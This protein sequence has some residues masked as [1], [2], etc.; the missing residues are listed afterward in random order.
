MNPDDRS[1]LEA[2]FAAAR[3]MPTDQRFEW[4]EK[5]C[6]DA[7]IRSEVADLLNHDLP[8]GFLGL[9]L[10]PH[11]MP[12]PIHDLALSTHDE[13]LRPERNA[14]LIS[15]S[16]PAGIDGRYQLLQRIGEGG[17]GIVY[18]AEELAPV[19][20]RVAIKLLKPGMDSKSVLARFD[21]ERQ[22][23]AMMDHPGIAKVLDGG[24]VSDGR[25]YFVMELVS[26][27]PIT[28]FCQTQACDHRTK[29]HLLLEV[30]QAVHHAHQKGI[31]HRDLKPSN[32]LVSMQDGKPSIKI[33]DFGIAKALHQPLTDRTLF[34]G[35]QQ[36]IGTPE[37]MSP[38][39]AETSVLGCDTRSDVYSLGVLAYELLTGTTPFDGNAIRK[40]GFSELQRTIREVDPPR[41]S[42]RMCSLGVSNTH[43]K[44]WHPIAGLKSDLDWLVMKALEKDRNRRYDSAQA[45][46]DDL[47]RWL[48]NEPIQARPPNWGYTLRKYLTKHRIATF[49][50]FALVTGLLLAAVGIGY[51]ISESRASKE[52]LRLSTQRSIELQRTADADRNRADSLTYG[53][54]MLGAFESF[55]SGRSKTT[56]ELLLAS[57]AS[58]RGLEWSW[59]SYLA[60]DRGIALLDPSTE[61]STVCHALSYFD[62]G[63]RLIAASRDGHLRIWDTRTARIVRSWYAHPSEIL[64][65]AV[66]P[67]GTRFVSG[68]AMG[69]VHVWD[70]NGNPLGTVHVDQPVTALAI[71]PRTHQVAI[72]GKQGSLQWLSW[73]FQG[74][75]KRVSSDARKHTGDIL[76]LAFDEQSPRLLSAGKGGVYVWDTET[77]SCVGGSGDFWQTYRFTLAPDF[78]SI[79][80]YGPPIEVWNVAQQP[81]IATGRWN[82]TATGISH[83]AFDAR[84]NSLLL[85]TADNC[86]QSVDLKTGEHD[87]VAYTKLSEIV[88]FA[89]ADD[90]SS[91]VVA[92][93]D[94]SLR[95]WPRDAW[96]SKTRLDGLR[97]PIAQ[98]AV[99]RIDQVVAIDESGRIQ[100]WNGRTGQSL[101]ELPSHSQQGFSIDV[102]PDGR[103]VVSYGLDQNLHVWSV[104]E[105]KSKGGCRLAL[106]ARSIKVHPS[107]KSV[108][109]GIPLG[110]VGDAETQEGRLALWD[111]E[112][113]RVVRTFDGLTNWAMHLEFSHD[114]EYLI[115]SSVDD[116]A[117]VWNMSD[118]HGTQYRSEDAEMTTRA[119]LSDDNAYVLSGLRDG[120]VY[121]WE[122]RGGTLVRKI[123]CHGDEITAMI[124]LNQDHRL[125]TA[126][127]SDSRIRIWNWMTGQCVAA[128]ESGVS[129]ITSIQMTQDEQCLVIGGADGEIRVLK[130]GDPV[131]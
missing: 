125:I 126:C 128:I 86:I 87:T 46:A 2:W 39:Q 19:R 24:L 23:L 112:S 21:A 44:E 109:C 75:P 42:E 123:V 7:R 53:N 10:I 4:L 97:H 40:L 116:G 59:L 30:C 131:H 120:Q 93:S 56:R 78:E 115:A 104:P 48:H 100:T 37:Y 5:N 33:I 81:A 43:R 60:D 65:L 94:G 118:S 11:G 52:K 72:G 90:G 17:F 62:S 51:G 12:F 45:M 55:Q 122:R 91:L 95:Y 38:E 88:K 50:T 63:N 124:C 22:A 1:T 20:R 77:A 102:T 82:S 127:K 119:I 14:D 32:I 70:G 31:I 105:S 101:G 129:G 98:I 66:T 26:G 76:C 36:M 80:V 47:W 28:E 69:T 18:M 8:D 9:P 103:Y 84:T 71:S 64:S 58:Q 111:L 92:A 41:P 121:V 83:A 73:D 49:I 106:G 74:E 107:G 54:A 61:S 29:M 96:A 110:H 15:E 27:V 114:G 89:L 25:S 79:G 34:T 35:F 67:D 108:A 16:L 117:M 130:V 13:P 85:A 99:H 6:S 3:E 57:P 68:D 113:E